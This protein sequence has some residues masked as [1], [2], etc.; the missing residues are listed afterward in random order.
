MSFQFSDSSIKDVKIIAPKMF[1]DSRGL[2]FETY[3][4]SEFSVHG[5]PETFV[6]E[7]I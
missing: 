2:F 6:Q 5:N 4:K 7:N 3:K 1:S